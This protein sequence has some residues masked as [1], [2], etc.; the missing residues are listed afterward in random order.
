[1]TA[2]K[3]VVRSKPATVPAVAPTNEFNHMI[4]M[5]ISGNADL[6][7]LNQLLDMKVR[8]DQIEAEKSF[9]RSLA[10]FQSKQAIIEKDQKGHNDKKYAS[11]G[12]TLAAVQ[13][14]MS[15]AGLSRSWIPSQNESGDRITITCEIT[16]VDGHKKSASLT[17]GADMSGNKNAIQG[18]GSTVS[19]L[20]RYTFYA[21]LGIASAEMIDDDGSYADIAKRLE[22]CTKADLAAIRKLIKATDTDEAAFVE[23]LQNTL[24]INIETLDQLPLGKVAEVTNAL[25]AKKK[26]QEKRK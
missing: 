9:N 24:K 8:Y 23:F 20:E 2:K 5:A 26:G 12:G 13:D 17:A 3:A 22:P 6:E 25:N 1:M 14:L 4:E 16:H 10:I 18:L 15:E 19:Y 7:K 11:L 21:A